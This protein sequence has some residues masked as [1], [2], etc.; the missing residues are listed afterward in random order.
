V[1]PAVAVLLGW[2]IAGEN[3]SRWSI[4]A[5]FIIVAA[6]ALVSTG[7]QPPREPHRN[8]RDASVRSVVA[9]LWSA[10]ARMRRADLQ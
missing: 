2:A 5:L 8:A 4:L 6:I 9:A 7:P 1:N 3:V 10:R